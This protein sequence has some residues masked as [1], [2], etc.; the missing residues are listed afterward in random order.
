MDTVYEWHRQ[1]YFFFI[2]KMFLKNTNRRNIPDGI[3]HNER[4]L[5]SIPVSSFCCGSFTF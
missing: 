2:L 1:I 5:I 3:T 4:V